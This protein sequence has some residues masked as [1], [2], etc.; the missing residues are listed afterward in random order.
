MPVGGSPHSTNIV[1]LYI[2]ASYSPFLNCLVQANWG[3][4]VFSALKMIQWICFVSLSLMKQEGKSG[5]PSRCIPTL[6]STSEPRQQYKDRY[7]LNIAVNGQRLYTILYLI[8]NILFTFPIY[9]N[10]P[11]MWKKRR[12]RINPDISYMLR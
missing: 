5:Q 9:E 10:Q 4:G 3:V 11:I 7:I 1:M 12:N 6:T 8:Y 2:I